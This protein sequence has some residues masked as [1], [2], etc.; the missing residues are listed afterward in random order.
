MSNDDFEELCKDIVRKY[1]LEHLDK[2]DKVESFL[3]YIVW[4]CKTLQNNK[5]LVSTSL[6]DGMYYEITYNGD[7]KELYLDAYKKFENRCIRI[8]S[9]EN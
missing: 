3:V 2:T 8:E 1:A 6:S 4:S 5:A 7:K 9:E